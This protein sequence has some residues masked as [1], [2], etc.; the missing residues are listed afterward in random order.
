MP[1]ISHAYAFGMVQALSRTLLSKADIERLSDAK[2]ISEVGKLLLE[3]EWGEA[4]GRREIEALSNEH[5]LD[6]C[7]FLR[8][9]SAEPEITDCFLL[10]YDI[11]NLKILFKSRMLNK[12]PDALSE[13]GT[14][15]PDKLR[16]CVDEHNYFALPEMFRE[17]LNSL[18][19]RVSIEPSPFTVDV[20]LDKL[21]AKIVCERADKTKSDVLK[22]YFTAWAET[23][24]LLIAL[25]CAA[26]KKDSEFL[27]ALL[28]PGGT[29]SGDVYERIFSEPERA[30]AHIQFRPY[31]DAFKEALSKP[32]LREMITDVESRRGGVLFSLIEP[33]KT[34]PTSIL[35][36]VY[37]LLAREREAS[38]IR[39]ITIAKAAR[40]P[41]EQL[42]S[43]LNF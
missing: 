21:Y 9:N 32:I 6:A 18:E 27:R 22:A 34:E 8:T 7:R 19:K 40:M 16:H 39:M 30:Y 1:Q 28:V 26:M 17:A 14:I 23:T 4:G 10:K 24:N 20:Q 5:I 37:Y 15:E 12:A 43:Y 35:P 33:H 31:A 42:S 11:L 38:A 41:G 3:M 36:A 25:R 2:S 13:C 29:L